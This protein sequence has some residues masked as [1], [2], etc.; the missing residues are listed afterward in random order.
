M[1]YVFAMLVGAAFMAAMLIGFPWMKRTFELPADW[2][3][4][5][6]SGTFDVDS[7]A[8]GRGVGQDNGDARPGPEG[9]SELRELI[10]AQNRRRADLV[11]REAQID[12]T[13]NDIQDS[14]A[15][16][17][18]LQLQIEA[19]LF[20]Q[21]DTRLLTEDS[22]RA[23]RQRQQMNAASQKEKRR[24]MVDAYRSMSPEGLAEVVQDLAKEEKTQ[25]AVTVLSVL[26]DRK[27]A[28][29]LALVAEPQPDLAASLTEKLKDGAIRLQ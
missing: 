23:K 9:N 1:R 4:T 2:Q 20:D 16:I 7:K 21:L 13:W 24:L 17:T 12:R 22:L 10:E 29:V 3:L 27:A 6:G 8:R 15:S 5:G 25:S 11:Q 14:Q 28:R 19:E 26:E 18:R